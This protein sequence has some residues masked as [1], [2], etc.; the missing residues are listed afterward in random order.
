MFVQIIFSELLNLLLQN[1]VWWYIIMS[2]IIFQKDWFAV[3]KVKVTVKD[4]QNMTFKYII[5]TVDPF[6]TKL[7]LMV[8]HRK[9]D[10]PVK[11]LDCSVVVQLK[12]TGKVQ[13]SSECSSGL[14]V[15]SFWT[16]CNQTWYGDATSLAKVSCK[17]IGLLSSSS[18][19]LWGL[20]VIWSNVT[21]STMSAE[22]LIFL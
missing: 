19:S 20:R 18:G 12:V 14:Y 6:V 21:V 11:R 2:Q 15:L 16:V 4:N 8:H 5:W 17:K 9:V 7:G 1:L 13:N 10:C 22:L 3:S